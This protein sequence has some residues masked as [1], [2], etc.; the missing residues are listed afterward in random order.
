MLLPL[1]GPAAVPEDFIWRMDVERNHAMIRAG[2]LTDDDPIE[3]LE[4]WFVAK[5][6]KSPPHS[7]A[8]GEFRHVIEVMLPPDW[9]VYSHDPITTA[10][11]E[12]EPDGL[13]VRGGLRDYADRHPGPEDVALVVEI[14]DVTLTRDRMLKKR[15]YARAAVPVYWIVNLVDRQIEVYTDPT[16]PAEEPTY[17]QRQDYPADAQVPVVVGGA[18]VGRLTVADLL[19]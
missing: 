13:V 4:G 5:M 1:K 7:Y 8:T 10:D 15:I 9:H 6:R 18:E 19:P 12:P 16:G 14:A 11:S 3:L 2:L 17:R